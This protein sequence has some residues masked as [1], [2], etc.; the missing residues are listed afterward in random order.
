MSWKPTQTGFYDPHQWPRLLLLITHIWEVFLCKQWLQSQFKLGELR[1]RITASPKHF[2]LSSY[3]CPTVFYAVVIE[4]QSS[5]HGQ[6]VKLVTSVNVSLT[7]TPQRFN[8]LKPPE[9]ILSFGK[10]WYLDMMKT[11]CTPSTR[12]SVSRCKAML[13]SERSDICHCSNGQL[14]DGTDTLWVC[15]SHYIDLN[16]PLGDGNDFRGK[17][18]PSNSLACARTLLTYT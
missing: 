13:Q 5:P 3:D 15:T 8:S 4:E 18:G 9:H 2:S 1:Y 7:S 16:N 14:K 10:G 17:M 11:V 12:R 6:G